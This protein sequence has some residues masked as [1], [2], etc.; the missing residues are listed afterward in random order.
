MAMTEVPYL[1]HS[2]HTKHINIWPAQNENKIVL[3]HPITGVKK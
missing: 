3:C 2:E 1:L